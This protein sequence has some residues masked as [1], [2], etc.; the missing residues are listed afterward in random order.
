MWVRRILNWTKSKFK[1]MLGLPMFVL[2]LIDG[3]FLD[4]YNKL[5]ANVDHILDNV[6]LPAIV[7]SLLRPHKICLQL[8]LISNFSIITQNFLADDSESKAIIIFT[9]YLINAGCALFYLIVLTSKPG[10]V[11][12]NDALLLFIIKRQPKINKCEPCDLVKPLRSHH[13]EICKQCVSKFEL[14]SDWFYKD[15]GS[16]NCLVYLFFLI[17]LNS[18]LLVSTLMMVLSNFLYENFN[19]KEALSLIW[20]IV[21]IYIFIKVYNFSKGLLKHSLANLTQ[22]ERYNIIRLPYLWANFGKVFY[23]PF[24]KGFCGN[25]RELFA[26]WLDKKNY[27]PRS[28]N[29]TA[30]SENTIID[31]PEQNPVPLGSSQNIKYEIC[32]TEIL[33]T[34]DG[35][36]YEP[37]DKSTIIDVNWNRLRIYS[38]M[39]VLNSPIRQ[40]YVASIPKVTQ[41]ITITH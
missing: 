27:L 40:A 2:K 41:P 8:F 15:I 31:I 29:D 10:V 12:K 21:S 22:Y 39:D 23:N 9:F 20:L 19:D 13:C 6:E 32:S 16:R 1:I 33:Y 36:Y 18:L 28:T 37:Y 25:L 14:H 3:I 38:V 7:V 17:S 5:T 34:E 24:D 4:F 30:A 26:N 35:T 11:Q